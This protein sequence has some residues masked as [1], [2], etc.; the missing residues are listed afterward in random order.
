M[1]QAATMCK[2]K[3]QALP[4]FDAYTQGDQEKKGVGISTSVYAA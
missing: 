3:I 4:N 2:E 1:A